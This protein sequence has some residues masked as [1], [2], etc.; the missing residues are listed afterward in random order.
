MISKIPKIIHQS[1][2]D[3]NIPF[4]V[5]KKSWI[6][7]WQICH[8]G[9]EKMFWTDV[10]NA[11]LVK[12]CYPDFYDF[13][14]SLSPNIKKAD[15]CRFL[16]MHRYG[17]VYVDLDFICLKNLSP[18]LK[19]Y[20]LVLGSTSLDN[21]YYQIPNAFMASRPGLDFWLNAARDAKNAPPEEQ[22][23]EKHAGPFRLQWAFYKYQPEH[24]IVYGHELIYPFDWIHFTGWNN[25]KYFKK[26]RV[27]LAQTLQNKCIEEIAAVFPKAYCLTFWTH[28]W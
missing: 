26:D 25:G 3:E 2:K 18:L 9:W 4:D 16:Y 24:S 5:Y 21:D 27:Q 11:A 15:F 17:G 8:P 19:E 14:L 6:D 22:T 7:S 12:D 28:N 23:V 1:W 13:Y 10:Q 20:E